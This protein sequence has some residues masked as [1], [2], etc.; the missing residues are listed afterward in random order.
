M[1]KK[2]RKDDAAAP[3]GGM[4]AARTWV[5]EPERRLEDWEVFFS[6]QRSPVL[7]SQMITAM[8]A[9][10]PLE[11]ERLPAAA[12]LDAV[13]LS[14]AMRSYHE[15]EVVDDYAAL[16]RRA[17]AAWQDPMWTC[18]VF[19]QYHCNIASFIVRMGNAEF[20]AYEDLYVPDYAARLLSQDVPEYFDR[21][22]EEAA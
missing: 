22:L 2:R 18:R 6:R 3:S 5:D 17:D 1:A 11:V 21:E 14:M 7:R 12:L 16:L 4:S 15:A 8:M 9:G 10:R 19:D 20:V 13:V